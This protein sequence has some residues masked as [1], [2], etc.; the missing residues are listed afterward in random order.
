MKTE[1]TKC[2]ETSA[3][4]IQTPGNYTEESLQQDVFDLLGFCAASLGSLLVTFQGSISAPLSRVKMLKKMHMIKLNVSVY[5]YILYILHYASKDVC[6][7]IYNTA[8]NIS[9]KSKVVKQSKFTSFM[10]QIY[11]ELEFV[12]MSPH[13]ASVAVSIHTSNELLDIYQFLLLRHHTMILCQWI[14]LMYHVNSDRV[15]LEELSNRI[16]STVTYGQHFCWFC[17]Y[18]CM[19]EAF[20]MH[21]QYY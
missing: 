17:L 16:M 20:V 15:L 21:V 7:C 10:N 4:K 6:V 5:R 3:Y 2:S 18:C 19:F 13:C 1:K 12:F 11:F 14:T 9:E 8:L